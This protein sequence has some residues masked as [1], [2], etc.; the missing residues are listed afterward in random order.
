MANC[1]RMFLHCLANN[2]LVSLRQTIDAL[3]SEEGARNYLDQD[4]VPAEACTGRERRHQF[5]RRREAEPLGEGH[6]CTCQMRPNQGDSS[7]RAR[8]PLR[9]VAVS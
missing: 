2:L 6:A 3:P 8:V 9:L 1:F 4:V 5:N 7:P